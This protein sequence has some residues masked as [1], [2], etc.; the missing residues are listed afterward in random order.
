[1]SCRHHAVQFIQVQCQPHVSNRSSISHVRLNPAAI[2]HVHK[3]KLDDVLAEAIAAE[4]DG[5]D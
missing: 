3:D 4:S 2:S 1:M 5:I